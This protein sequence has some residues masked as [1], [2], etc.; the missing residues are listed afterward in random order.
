MVNKEKTQPKMSVLHNIFTVIGIVLCVVFSILLVCNITLIVKGTINTDVPPSVL[1]KTPLAVLSGSMSGDAPD[2][3]EVGDLIIVDTIQ[4]EK[5]KV[6]DIIAFK[7]GS[8]VVTH[9]II[10]ISTGD[11]GN[12]TFSTKG[13]ANNTPDQR[14]VAED[15][16]I[17]IFKFRIPEVGNFVLFMQTPM[18]MAL[19]IGVPVLAFIVYDILRRQIYHNKENKK[20]AELQAELER[21]RALAGERNDSE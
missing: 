9:R 15:E 19:F 5:L 17:G 7:Q 14:P 16:L 18:G 8:T 6:G 2:H 20:T 11:D 13:D 12:L 10:E 3:I 21:L 4:P 1:G